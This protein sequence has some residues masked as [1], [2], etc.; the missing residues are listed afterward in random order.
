MTYILIAITIISAA[1]V[2]VMMFAIEEFKNYKVYF[3]IGVIICFVVAVF[4]LVGI[5]WS[6]DR[7]EQK[8][9]HD[10]GGMILNDKCVGVSLQTKDHQ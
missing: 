5:F 3:T 9:C 6:I 10:V 7:N 4:S 1:A 2:F 8:A